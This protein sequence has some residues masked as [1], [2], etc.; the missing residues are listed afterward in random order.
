M[1]VRVEF[2]GQLRQA[3]GSRALEVEVREGGCVD[4]AVRAAA[5]HSGALREMLL[6]PKGE[7]RAA[8]LVAAAGRQVTRAETT[9]LCAGEVVVLGSPLAGG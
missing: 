3:A 9:R 1:R 4:D 5:A 6:D 7:L 2:L 8:L